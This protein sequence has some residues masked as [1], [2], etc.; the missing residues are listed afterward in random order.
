MKPEK[1]TVT[2]GGAEMQLSF[3][4]AEPCLLSAEF[5][6][7]H[8]P[9]AEVKGHGPGQEVLQTG[10]LG[11]RI[12]AVERSGNYAILI[13]FDDG[14]DTGIYSWEYLRELCEN[15]DHYW[16]RYLDRL[17]EAGKSR[18]PEIQPVKFMDP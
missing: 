17:S 12:V 9:S 3:P 6:R 15:R 11:V 13:R 8:S 1:I 16:N 4:G 10:K 5:L 7:V 2:K 14:H 18:D